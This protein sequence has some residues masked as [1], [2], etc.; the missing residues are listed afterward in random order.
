MLT[1]SL[2][3]AQRMCDIPKPERD[4]RRRPGRSSPGDPETR[5]DENPFQPDEGPHQ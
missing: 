4:N 3:I 1:I 2:A 5:Y